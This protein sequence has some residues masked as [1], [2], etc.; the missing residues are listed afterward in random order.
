MRIGI[1]GLSCECSTFSPL[2]TGEGDFTVLCGDALPGRFGFLADFPGIEFIPLLRARALPGGRIERSF[3]DDF[4]DRLLH[5]I[6]GQGPFDGLLLQ[7]HGASAITA[8]CVWRGCP[9]GRTVLNA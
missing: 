8:R 9:V 5:A 4:L 2:A 6:V 7:M 1:A 3:Y